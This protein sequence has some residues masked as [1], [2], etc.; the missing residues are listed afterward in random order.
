MIVSKGKRD[1]FHYLYLCLCDP[2]AVRVIFKLFV[3]FP[4][5]LFCQEPPFQMIQ[6]PLF[7]EAFLGKLCDLLCIQYCLDFHTPYSPFI[8]MFP[9][10][11]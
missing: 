3:T 6:A 7:F 8:S 1:S 9:I 4:L 2:D 11:I 10:C 5:D